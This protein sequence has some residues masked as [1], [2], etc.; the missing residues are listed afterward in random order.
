MKTW[1]TYLVE[2]YRPGASFDDLNSAV[3]EVR[4]AA[5][6]MA[7]RRHPVRCVHYTI[8]PS[9]E[10]FLALFEARAEELVREV[11]AHAKVP[12]ERITGAVSLDAAVD[13]LASPKG[14]R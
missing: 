4:L 9:D 14:A 11:Y 5:M 7:R 3:R 1:E 12:F 6:E 2:H 10:A 8:V 13:S